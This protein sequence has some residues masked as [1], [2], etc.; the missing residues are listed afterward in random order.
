MKRILLSLM[1]CIIFT[2]CTS[3]P[4]NPESWME[5]Q[6][7]ACLP[8]AI[9]FRE[10]LKK[11]N[12]WSEVIVYHWLDT[13]KNKLNG[14]AIVAYMYPTGKNQ[15]WTYDYW[16]SYRIRAFKDDPVD[17]AQK[18]VNARQEDRYVSYAEFLK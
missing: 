8:T 18:A 10:G 3:T 15:L 7:N 12:V 13:K 6:K 4:K 1:G 16:G 14:H 9:S 17:I 2:S 5:L 11:Y